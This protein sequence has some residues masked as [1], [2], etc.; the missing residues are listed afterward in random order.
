[1]NVLSDKINN[2]SQEEKETKDK[3]R[4]PR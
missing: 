1:M 4:L 3:A 2:E